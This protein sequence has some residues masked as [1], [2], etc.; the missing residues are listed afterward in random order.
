ME[1]DHKKKASMLRC[2][3]LATL[4]VTALALARGAVC[5]IDLRGIKGPPEV[6]TDYSLG[7]VNGEALDL[8]TNGGHPVKGV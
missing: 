7:V 5:A 4:S 1:Q 3:I 2:L 8:P 6:G